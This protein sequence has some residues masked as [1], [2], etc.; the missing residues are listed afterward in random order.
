MKKSGL[1]SSSKIAAAPSVIPSS[2]NS[3]FDVAPKKAIFSLL[4]VTH[5]ATRSSLTER[6]TIA[7]VGLKTSVILSYNAFFISSGEF[8]FID[9]AFMIIFLK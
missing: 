8:P 3:S 1:T 9:F 7:S 2:V 4:N 5:T 6:N